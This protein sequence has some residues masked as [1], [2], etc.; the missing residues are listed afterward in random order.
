ML[1]KLIYAFHVSVF[2]F[3]SFCV[4]FRLFLLCSVLLF[5]NVCTKYTKKC[6]YLRSYAF[7]H[8]RLTKIIGFNQDYFTQLYY[9]FAYFNGSQSRCDNGWRMIHTTYTDYLPM[10]IFFCV[11]RD[12]DKDPYIYRIR[13][14][15]ELMV[16]KNWN[17][18]AY[19]FVQSSK[20]PWMWYVITIYI[21]FLASH[22]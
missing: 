7:K 18:V 21:F 8:T 4:P 2:L 10:N 6:V 15:V 14:T 17:F 1:F 16:S 22:F 11:L 19:I 12:R 3:H 13:T 5:M 20:W 9:L